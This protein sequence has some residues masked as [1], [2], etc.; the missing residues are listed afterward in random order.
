[1]LEWIPS[2]GMSAKYQKNVRKMSPKGE[3]SVA[4]FSYHFGMIS[5]FSNMIETWWH[6]DPSQKVLYTYQLIPDIRWDFLLAKKEK[7]AKT[8]SS[9]CLRSQFAYSDESGNSDVLF[10]H[11]SLKRKTAFRSLSAGTLSMIRS[12]KSTPPKVFS[13]LFWSYLRKKV[14][15][16]SFW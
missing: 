12:Q 8:F 1:M 5:F 7:I 9:L 14:T 16:D 3:S 10:H 11:K 13:P 4:A 2:P 15:V 6:Y